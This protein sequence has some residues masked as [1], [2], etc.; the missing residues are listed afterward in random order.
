[1]AFIFSKK[2]RTKTYFIN[3]CL[4]SS[5][6][7]KK[8]VKTIVLKEWKNRCLIIIKIIPIIIQNYLNK[9]R[10]NIGLKI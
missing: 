8:K 10:R 2:S 5:I 1:M 6:K 3:Y 7:Y 9:L 4:K